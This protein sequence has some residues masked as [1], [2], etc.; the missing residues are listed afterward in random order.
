M[1]RLAVLISNKGIGTNLQAII[2]GVENGKINGKIALVVSDVKEA[3]GLDLAKKHKIPFAICQNKES[4][5]SLL[6]KNK[7][8]Y[9]CLAGWKQFLTDDVINGYQNKILNLHPGLIPNSFTGVVKNPDGTNGLWNKKQFANKALESFLG[10]RVTYAGS[11]IHFLTKEVDFGLVLGRCF[12]KIKPHDT[13]YS[14]YTRLKKK[15]NRLYV[16]VLQRL[17]K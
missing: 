4:L 8:D 17:C 6:K 13:I 5:L 9:V 3:L 1:K 11:S 15:E 14:L 12:E 2:D 10:K 16:K 7:I